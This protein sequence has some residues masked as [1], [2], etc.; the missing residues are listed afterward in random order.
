MTRWGTIVLVLLAILAGVF[1]FLLEPRLTSTR[2]EAASSDSV[3]HF[4]PGAIRKVTV[5]SEGAKF[6]LRAGDGGW[7]VGPKPKDIA[8]EKEV[9][10]L[11]EEAANLQIFDVIH[12]SE[13]KKGGHSLSD[14][15]LAKPRSRIELEGTGGGTLYFGKDAAA[16]GRIYVRR[17]DS[18]DVYVVRDILQRLAFRNPQDFRMKRLSDL[19]P[20]R[21]DRFTIKRDGGEIAL[22]RSGQGWEIVRPLRA[23]ADD[24]AV[25]KLLGS[26]LGL[27]IVDFVADSAND[28]SAYGLEEP[29]A[30]FSMEADGASR[31]Q[32]LRIGGD[33]EG[34]S[35]VL[36]QFTARDSVYHLP[37]KAWSLLQVSP[38]D[39]R[40][41]RIVDLNLDTVDA[42]HLRMDGKEQVIQHVADGWKV[43]GREISSD[44]IRQMVDAIT[45]A[46]SQQYLP[47][48]VENLTRT[49]LDKPAKQIAFEAWLS[50]NTPE[51][52]AG[53]R[54]I[55]TIALGKKDG[56][57]AYVR[58][59]EDPEIC[60][61][62][63]SLID[64][65]RLQ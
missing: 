40:D 54:P 22:E 4:A 45:S 53:H 1:I 61:I 2:D 51:E 25:E 62:P 57:K 49:G 24:A 26:L 12:A 9:S 34:G 48:T 46:K 30:E 19:T 43:D 55:A 59:N 17:A 65:V 39:L 16:E 27:E 36:A 64:A 15:G 10:D 3:F 29:R 52:S 32:A 56:D 5:E 21:I 20:D 58:I 63:A 33:V 8:S 31:P 35:A 11:L 13:F 28:L 47:L 14:F 42:I 50:E 23:R 37:A 60:V 41:R 44:A 18:D 7:T 6:E 38:E